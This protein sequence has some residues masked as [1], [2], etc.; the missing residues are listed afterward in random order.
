MEFWTSGDRML[1]DQPEARK[2][3]NVVGAPATTYGTYM[4]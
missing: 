3:P 4:R 1:P 2:N